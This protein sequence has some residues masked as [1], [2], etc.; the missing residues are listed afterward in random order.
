[1][2]YFIFLL[3]YVSQVQADVYKVYGEDGHIHYRSTIV[4]KPITYYT[5]EPSY[6]QQV[7]EQ[8]LYDAYNYQAPKTVDVDI[9]DTIES[10]NDGDE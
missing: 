2:R 9:D 3:L 1:M 6:S 7:L 10:D 8:H 4:D 5:N